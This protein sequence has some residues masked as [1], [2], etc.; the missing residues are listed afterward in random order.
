MFEVFSRTLTQYYED[1]HTGK[2][3][4]KAWKAEMGGSPSFQQKLLLSSTEPGEVKDPKASFW[5]K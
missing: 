1:A 4:D 5:N 2:E 3:D